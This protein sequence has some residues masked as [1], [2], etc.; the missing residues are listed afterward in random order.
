MGNFFQKP[1]KSIKKQKKTLKKRMNKKKSKKKQKGGETSNN[2]KVN[3]LFK[4]MLKYQH[5]WDGM[6]KMKSVGT[7]ASGN[8]FYFVNEYKTFNEEEKNELKRC[9]SS[10]LERENGYYSPVEIYFTYSNNQNY[11]VLFYLPEFFMIACDLIGVTLEEGIK[12]LETYRNNN[13]NKY[14]FIYLVFGDYYKKY[15]KNRSIE[16]PG[17]ME[18]FRQY[19][20]RVG[21]ENANS[22][23]LYNKEY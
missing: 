6:S 10:Y 23:P 19:N 21:I 15:F 7:L 17:F 8:P 11:R 2:P 3:N 18:L 4:E 5:G 14:I 12:L 16:E 9:I 1:E 13:P 20:E 22:I